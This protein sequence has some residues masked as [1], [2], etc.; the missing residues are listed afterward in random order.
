MF[1]EFSAAILGH[2][3]ANRV[4]G[5]ACENVITR[6][7]FAAAVLEISTWENYNP[8]PLYQLRQLAKKLNLGDIL[9]KDEGPRFNLGSFKALGGAYAGLRVLQRQ[10]RLVT[11]KNVASADIHQGLYSNELKNI[12][13]ASAT[14]GNHGRSLAWGAKMFGAPCNI[15]IHSEVSEGRAQAMRDLGA[16]VVRIEGDYDGSVRQV[17]SDAQDN[18]WHVVSDTSWE[19]Y[20]IVP[21]EVM[22]GYG[23]M[24]D[25]ICRQVTQPPTHLFAQGGV[26]GLAAALAAGFRQFWAD[27]SPRI[28]IVEPELAAC[29]LESAK[30]REPTTVTISEETLMAG[31]SCGEPSQIAWKILRQEAQDYLTIPENLVGLSMRL[32][33]RPIGDDPPIV[34]GESAIAG[35]AALISAACEDDLRNNLG[36]DASSRILLIGSEGATDQEIYDQIVG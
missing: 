18:G 25:E 17:R 9:Y 32:A 33:A 15:Y 35:L 6:K 28:V 29:L 20:T 34:A 21:T 3:R 4:E 30:N 26:G 5:D 1:D 10:L 23:M 7:D 31:L 13:L 36:L 2:V 19:G 22:A 11:G 24:V 27:K 12:T 16:N 8:T 14:D